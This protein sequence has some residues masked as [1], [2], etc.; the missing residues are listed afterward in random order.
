MLVYLSGFTRSRPSAAVRACFGRAA[1]VAYGVST[2]PFNSNFRWKG[3]LQLP[4]AHPNA[5]FESA[6]LGAVGLTDS[7]GTLR[8]WNGS[9][10]TSGPGLTEGHL[11][12]AALAIF[13]PNVLNYGLPYSTNYIN[14]YDYVPNTFSPPMVEDY[15][16]SRL[17]TFR[18]GVTRL[19]ELRFAD[20]PAQRQW[21]KTYVGNAE[22]IPSSGPFEVV[23]PNGS[24][25]WTRVHPNPFELLSP[26]TSA[27]KQ[28]RIRRVG[29]IGPDKPKPANFPRKNGSTTCIGLSGCFRTRWRTACAC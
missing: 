6:T 25:F 2:L 15:N 19:R 4:W 27:C 17:L 14:D 7:A 10:W 1:L 28:S 29:L 26:S 12:D 13:V 9:A 21:Q 16:G 18:D 23:G 11:S 8:T 22:P 5:L 24:Y 3:T 20:P